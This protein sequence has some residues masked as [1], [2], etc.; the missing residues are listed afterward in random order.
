MIRAKEPRASA[1]GQT[2]TI[3]ALMCGV[4]TPWRKPGDQEAA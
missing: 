2:L 3:T 1:S 4:T